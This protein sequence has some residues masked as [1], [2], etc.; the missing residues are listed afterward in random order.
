MTKEELIERLAHYEHRSWAR[1]QAYLHSQCARNP[2]GSLIIPA[3]LVERWERQISTPYDELTE[4]E[5]QSDRDEV[6]HILPVIMEFVEDR[7]PN[8]D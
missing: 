6:A 2:D 7:Q 5:K 8:E 1:W 3:A 4:Q